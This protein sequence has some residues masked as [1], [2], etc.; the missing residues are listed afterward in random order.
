MEEGVFKNDQPEGL[1]KFYYDNGK[2]RT[3]MS[4]PEFSY[5]L[6]EYKRDSIGNV[7]REFI[8]Y[9]TYV[10]NYYENGLLESEGNY[11]DSK[12]DGLWKFY[13]ENGSLYHEDYYKKGT[14]SG[15]SRRYYE[16]G[17]LE[18]EGNWE[19]EDEYVILR[20]GFWKFYYKNGKL[21]EEGNFIDDERIG[22]WKIYNE[23]GQ[24][25]E[26]VNYK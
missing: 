2:L 8:K 15:L 5:F 25:K 22:L 17:Q 16:N 6:W 23:S 13:N 19:P 12:K 10:K 21:K 18:F 11:I 1:Y 7:T 20:Q 3:E 4:F 9:T 14:I 24:L 26:E